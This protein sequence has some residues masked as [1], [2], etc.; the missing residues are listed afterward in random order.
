MLKLNKFSYVI[1]YS[2]FYL[3]TSHVKVKP[4]SYNQ[5]VKSIPNLNTSHVKVKLYK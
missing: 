1:Y 2:L 4:N 5:A 3:N